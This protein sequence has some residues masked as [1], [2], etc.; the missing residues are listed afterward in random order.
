VSSQLILPSSVV[1]ADEPG[2]PSPLSFL[3]SFV[4]AENLWG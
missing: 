3:P 1:S 2:L 4:L